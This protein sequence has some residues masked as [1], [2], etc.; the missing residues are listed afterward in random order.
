M[1]AVANNPAVI[2]SSLQTLVNAFN[3]DLGLDE[4]D[5]R[6][7]FGQENSGG[8]VWS[9]IRAGGLPFGATWTYDRGYM[10]AAS[11]RA[12]AERAIATR[13]GGSQLVWSTE[14]LGRIPASAGMHPSAFVWLNAKGALDLISTLAP[15]PALTELVARRDPVLVVFDGSAE[16]IH[17]ASRA[18]ITGLIMDA[19][20]LESLS[21]ARE[22]T[23][24]E[25]VR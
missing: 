21:R 8:R 5:K 1:A 13:N 10:V 24:I 9:T 25:T 4:Q 14:F 11:D 23:Q 22:G 2:D 17:A 12:S 16:Q 3:A 19:M 7:V 15:S 20:L 18:R 6:I